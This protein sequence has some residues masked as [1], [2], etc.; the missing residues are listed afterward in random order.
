MSCPPFLVFSAEIGMDAGLSAA[1]ALLIPVW[2][3][4]ASLTGIWFVRVNSR[5]LYSIKLKGSCLVCASNPKCSN[6]CQG[7]RKTKA[8]DV[9]ESE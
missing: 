6:V 2:I 5:L 8:K 1:L 9:S 3:A 4:F 7:P